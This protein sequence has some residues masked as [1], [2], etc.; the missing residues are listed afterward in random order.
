MLCL[1]FCHTQTAAVVVAHIK[2]HIISSTYVQVV[3][4]SQKYNFFFFWGGRVHLLDLNDNKKIVG[5]LNIALSGTRLRPPAAP[6]VSLQDADN[7]KRVGVKGDELKQLVLE[8]K[9]CGGV[10]QGLI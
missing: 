7:Q 5:I 2:F 6:R 10:H 8:W 9:K 4:V 3:P 1:I